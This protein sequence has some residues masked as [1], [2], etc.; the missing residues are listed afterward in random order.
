MAVLL[1][2]V[3]FFETVHAVV[4]RLL[5]PTSSG[6]PSNITKG[7]PK[8]GLEPNQGTP[9][10]R[11]VRQAAS[12]RY[13]HQETR[14]SMGTQTTNTDDSFHDAQDHATVSTPKK[15]L[16]LKKVSSSSKTMKSAE[17]RALAIKRAKKAMAEDKMKV[18]A[19]KKKRAAAMRRA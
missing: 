13:S 5:F 3:A 10:T 19:V 18:E 1:G 4:K 17:K 12:Y 11:S 2:S 14:P 7:Q 8:G 6:D 9:R 16:A 15:A